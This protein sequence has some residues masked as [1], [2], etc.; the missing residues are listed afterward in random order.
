MTEWQCVGAAADFRDGAAHAVRAFDTD[1]VAFADRAG[2]IHIF[3][4][5]CPH[6]GADLS[7]GR[8]VGDHLDCPAHQWRWNGAG[9]C[10]GG[11]PKP[12]PLR[13]WPTE[14]RDGQVYVRV[15]EARAYG[16]STRPGP[17]EWFGGVPAP[18]GER[19]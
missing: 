15:P 10:V 3:D 14:E 7:K 1:L 12:T 17:A 16:R 8:V 11:S 19:R 13:V 2:A 9:K 5:R 4:A 6:M 18:A